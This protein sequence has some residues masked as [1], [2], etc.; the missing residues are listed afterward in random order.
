VRQYYAVAGLTV[1]MREET[2]F[3]YFL[4]DNLGLRS[5]HTRA[6]FLP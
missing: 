1:V 5:V 3:S 6:I 2:I 4:T